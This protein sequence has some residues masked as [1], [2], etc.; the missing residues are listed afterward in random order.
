MVNLFPTLKELTVTLQPQIY[1][2]NIDRFRRHNLLR[3]VADYLEIKVIR[4]NF[5]KNL[6]QNKRSKS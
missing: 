4:Y 2:D 1:S 3:Y 6:I 5:F